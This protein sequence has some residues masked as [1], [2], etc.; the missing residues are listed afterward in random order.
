MC[1][2]CRTS[3]LSDSTLVGM[4]KQKLSFNDKLRRYFKYQRKLAKLLVFNTNQHRQG[5]LKKHLSRLK[6]NLQTLLISLKGGA[7]VAAMAG[8]MAF[9]TQQAQAQTFN[10][11]QLNP[12]SLTDIGFS[13]TPSI[14]DI[15]GDGDMDV[16]SGNYNG[17][18]SYFENT[19]GVGNTPVFVGVQTNPFFIN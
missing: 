14:V 18:F 2:F 17:N 19:A 1:Y 8:I 15:D 6:A 13:S 4:K 7:A 12:F 5:V 3:K 16:L 10:T 11:V 9:G